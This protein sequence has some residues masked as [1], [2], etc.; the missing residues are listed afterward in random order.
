MTTALKRTFL[1]IGALGVILA[2]YEY[3]FGPPVEC[4]W[5]FCSGGRVYA[6][7]IFFVTAFILLFTWA[8]A[9][10]VRSVR[11]GK[12][13]GIIILLVIITPFVIYLLAYYLIK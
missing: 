9:S 3:F 12:M 2:L 10:I 6:V 5:A 7:Y 4:Y 8:I 11:H 13:W 1:I